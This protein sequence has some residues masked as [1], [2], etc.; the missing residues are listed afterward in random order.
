MESNWPTQRKIRRFKGIR[1]DVMFPPGEGD[2][3]DIFWN[4]RDAEPPSQEISQKM[5]IDDSFLTI[6]ILQEVT[7]H[8]PEF[9]PK[10]SARRAAMI[11]RLYSVSEDGYTISKYTRSL[12]QYLK[13]YVISFVLNGIQ[14]QVTK[15]NSVRKNTLQIAII[16][17]Q[18]ANT[19]M[20][21]DQTMQ[22]RHNN[23]TL[24]T[25]QVSFD[26]SKKNTC[27]FPIIHTVI[28]GFGRSTYDK[29]SDGIPVTHDVT[30]FL[31]DIYRCLYYQANT[32]LVMER[33]FKLLRAPQSP[34]KMYNKYVD[35]FFV[36]FLFANANGETNIHSWEDVKKI[37]SFIIRNYTCE[38]HES[39]NGK[40]KVPEPQIIDYKNIEGAE[41]DDLTPMPMFGR[42]KRK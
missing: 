20:H 36:R 37:A 39:L 1:R 12:R 18:F 30:S 28:T 4:E 25:V 11:P 21:L 34:E 22:F 42:R 10:M 2:N 40:V 9:E 14:D 23:L 3:L 31:M 32:F 19:L 13:E 6:A 15:M 8:H 35:D 24:D 38:T 26:P 27:G 29:S 33:A 7:H 41:T 5:P 17:Y 16:L